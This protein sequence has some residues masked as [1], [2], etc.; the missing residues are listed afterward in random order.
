MF[1]L[2]K[3]KIILPSKISE[4]LAEETGLHIGDG[5]MNFYNKKGLYQLRGHIT[6]DKMHYD[7]RISKLYKDLYNLDISL[8]KMK[9]T[10]VY[11]FQ[12]WS[13]EMVLFKHKILKLPLGKKNT[14]KIPEI[15]TKKE[16]YL[17]ALIRGIFDTDGTFYLE[18]KNNSLYP[19]IEITTISRQ[20]YL[21][22]IKYLKNL[23]FRT[24][25]WVMK[26]KCYKPAYR[27][28]VRGRKMLNKWIK[29]ISPKNP[30]FWLKFKYY[31]RNS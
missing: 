27:V 20:L 4:E 26:R 22:L 16:E 2:P 14:I 19:R 28:T 23:D 7:T 10:R 24:T 18:P 31:L 12:I 21:Q 30:K 25:G 17:A 13:N 9:S 6:D 15:F 8:R 29:E 1:A 5:S 11:G 3:N